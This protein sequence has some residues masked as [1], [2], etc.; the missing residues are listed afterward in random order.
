MSGESITILTPT[1]N[2]GKQLEILY[3]SLK[4]QTLSGFKWLIIDDGSSDRTSE[5]VSLWQK[6]QAV[7]IVYIY[8]ENGGKHT[9]LN[10]GIPRIDSEL[11]FIV[12]SDDYLPENAI[13]IIMTY[14]NKYKDDEF[15]KK[16]C[17]YSFLRF[18]S[19]GEVNTAFFSENE[20]IASYLKVRI[21]EGIGGDKAEVFYT[22]V[23]KKYP[24]PVYPGEKFLPEDIVWMQMS[25]QYNM[26]HINECVY[27]CDYL[28]GGL[29]KS[30]R[31]MKIKSPQGMC[32]RSQIYL[33]NS[34]VCLKVKMKMMLLYM[35]YGKAA[36][37]N[38]NILFSDIQCK[39]LYIAFYLPGII[40]YQVWKLMYK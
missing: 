5:S 18:Y 24:F 6:E 34:D 4:K 7:E 1:F 3:N 39:A 9:A 22:D 17:G 26:V 36:G 19:N 40:F 30:G 15:E 33:N 2:R 23:L 37:K 10:N 13:E 31:K 12:D 32:L 16:L 38:N 8:K 20:E 11:T 25:E 14:H 21:N 29:T 28:D 35:I 27:Y